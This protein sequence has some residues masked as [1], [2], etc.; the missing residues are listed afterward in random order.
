MTTIMSSLPTKVATGVATGVVGGWWLV[1]CEV[2]SLGFVWPAKSIPK[3]SR[4]TAAAA[5]PQAKSRPPPRT[6][7]HPI[8]RQGHPGGDRFSG[9]GAPEQTFKPHLLFDGGAAWFTCC[10]V[11]GEPR[12][13]V[14][15]KV[16]V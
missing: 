11:R 9:R 6:Q 7:D 16:A 12:R 2:T 13:F 1:V 15:W 14:F 3:A 10:E 4:S 5:K 8:D